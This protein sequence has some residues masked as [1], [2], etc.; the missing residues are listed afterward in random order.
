MFR[1]AT[2][3]VPAVPHIPFCRRLER[4]VFANALQQFR[5]I[6]TRG[7]AKVVVG[8]RNSRRGLA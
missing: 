4:R 3:V 6:S 1:P 7:N 5:A 8:V 2:F